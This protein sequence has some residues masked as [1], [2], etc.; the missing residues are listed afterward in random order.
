MFD[1]GKLPRKNDNN[2]MKR[3]S[4]KVIIKRMLND[5]F[6]V[7][8]QNVMD[9]IKS[10]SSESGIDPSFLAANALQ[11]GMNNIIN[12]NKSGDFWEYA[13]DEMYPVSGYRYY[14]LDTFGEKFPELVKKGYLK[15][16]FSKRFVIDP[17]MN[18][19]KQNIKSA[20]FM[21]N[22]DAL[23]AKSA[24]IRDLGDT[25]DKYAKDNSIKLEPK[26]RDYFIMSA[27]NGGFG[28]AKIMM[29]EMSK[30]NM[31]QS[32]FIEK[33]FTSRKGVH[34][35]IVPRMDKIQMIKEILSSD[36][37]QRQVPMHAKMNQIM[38]MVKKAYGKK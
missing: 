24:M 37:T 12:E 13:D 32:D 22:R 19:K 31:P 18:E 29:D 36:E 20:Q 27:Y 35:N 16:E 8:K 4:E 7:D 25:V 30:S 3:A 10:V 21:T 5:K 28:N 14:G 11:E 1:I 26:S 38:E 17:K 9:L 2:S 23:M 6:P 34:K 15:D 33:G